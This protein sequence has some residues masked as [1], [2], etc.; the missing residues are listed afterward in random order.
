[1]IKRTVGKMISE[2]TG[3][4]IIMDFCGRGSS[5]VCFCVMD[6]LYGDYVKNSISLDGMIGVAGALQSRSCLKYQ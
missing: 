1:M 4:T 5:I 3:M 6:D 2:S